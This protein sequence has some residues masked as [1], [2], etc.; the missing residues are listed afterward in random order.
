MHGVGMTGMQQHSQMQQ[1]HPSLNSAANFVSPM[2][3]MASMGGLQATGMFAGG[4]MSSHQILTNTMAPAPQQPN[5]S[6]I[7]SALPPKVPD[8][9]FGSFESAYDSNK[10]PSVQ[11]VA[12]KLVL[13]SN[14]LLNLRLVIKLCT[15]SLQMLF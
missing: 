7:S 2:G 10:Q 9:D 6:F 5:M 4:G 15:N 13:R 8:A 3:A 14:P 11:S 12:T 1:I